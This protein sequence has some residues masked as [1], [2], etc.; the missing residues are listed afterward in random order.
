MSAVWMSIAWTSIAMMVVAGLTLGL[1]AIW[2]WQRPGSGWRS[3]SKAK[4]RTKRVRGRARDQYLPAYMGEH[5]FVDACGAGS[6]GAGD[7][8]GGDGGGG[9]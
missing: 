2:R 6:G 8:S 4:A 5:G 9:D 3:L 1:V 7:G